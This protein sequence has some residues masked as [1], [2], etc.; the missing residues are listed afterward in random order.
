MHKIFYLEG[1]VLF[2]IMGIFFFHKTHLQ[3]FKYVAGFSLALLSLII[4]L[5]LYKTIKE[6]IHKRIC[7][8]E[9]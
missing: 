7:V 4:L 2:I 6:I 1:E 3:F 5:L 9:E 8:E